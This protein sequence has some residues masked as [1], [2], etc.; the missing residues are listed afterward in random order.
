MIAMSKKC[1]LGALTL[2]SITGNT[3]ALYN[4]T[5]TTDAAYKCAIRAPENLDVAKA[6]IK[7]YY[8]S[9]KYAQDVACVA[10]SIR[11]YLNSIQL[12]CN[13]AVVF[14]VDDTV[15][16]SFDYSQDNNFG[17]NPKTFHKWEKTP[18]KAIPAMLELY[19]FIQSKGIT[20]FFVTGRRE[21]RRKATEQN[22]KSAGFTSWQGIYLQPEDD[23]ANSI[24]PFKS[25][26]RR[27]IEEQGYSIVANI[28][29][30]ESDLLGGYALKAFKVPNPIYTLD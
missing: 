12:P 19:H 15:I 3:C 23:N 21:N 16:C 27:Q 17:Y 11:R 5:C 4:Q 24:M 22:L 14:D 7:D 13:A 8:Q 10:D 1:I 30:Q 6:Q 9:G 28:G 20:I 26:A 2:L 25:A 18:K 29:D